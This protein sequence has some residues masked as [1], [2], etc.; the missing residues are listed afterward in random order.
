MLA[1]RGLN[2]EQVGMTL[3]IPVTEKLI[4]TVQAAQQ[5]GLQSIPKSSQP[6]LYADVLKG[7]DL[8]WLQVMRLLNPSESLDF[9]R[10]LIQKK[11]ERESQLDQLKEQVILYQTTIAEWEQK[12]VSL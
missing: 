9:Q 12:L 7:R 5:K 2:A 1:I 4:E 8:E 6:H 10:Y 3:S 11:R